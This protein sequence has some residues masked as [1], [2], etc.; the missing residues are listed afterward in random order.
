[1]NRLFLTA[2][3]ALV[4]VCGAPTAFA[5]N[6][7]GPLDRPVVQV[8]ANPPG[9]DVP[10][11]VPPNPESANETVPPAMPSDPNYAAGPYKGALTP[12]PV[13]AMNKVYPVCTRKLRDSCRN[14]GSR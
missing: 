9:H 11:P 13:E 6:T 14:P 1:M 10:S 2:G 5:Q 4:L 7:A 8:Q 12:P 3:T